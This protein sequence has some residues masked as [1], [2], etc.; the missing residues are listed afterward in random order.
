MP[1]YSM[2]AA[3]HTVLGATDGIR[4]ARAASHRR[5]WLAQRYDH[6]RGEP[7]PATAPEIRRRDQGELQGLDALV[8]ATG[9][10]SKGRTQC[11]AD[12]DRRSGIWRQWH[13]WRSNPDAGTRSDRGLGA[14]LNQLQLHCAVL[15]HAGSPDYRPESSLHGLRGNHGAVDRLPGL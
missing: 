9:S 10:A 8:A 7:T 6:D 13:V 14:A 15:A 3:R 2:R 1:G 5:A 12:H 4:H 11:A